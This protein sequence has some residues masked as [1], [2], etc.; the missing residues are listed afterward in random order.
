MPGRVHGAGGK[1]VT[2]FRA[3]YRADRPWRL[4]DAGLHLVAALLLPGPFW[5]QY[6]PD[7]CV[8]VVWWRSW[9]SGKFLPEADRA[10]VL[11]R[12]LHLRGATVGGAALLGLLVGLAGPVCVLH[13]VVHLAIDRLTHGKAWQ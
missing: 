5:L 2:E 10:L 4:L 8:G 13:Y 9:Q 12:W 1:E 3:A 7:I 11:H 6:V